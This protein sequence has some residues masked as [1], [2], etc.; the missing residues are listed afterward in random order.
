LI[1]VVGAIGVSW[2]LDPG[3]GVTLVVARLRTR[4]R[5]DFAVAG[6]TDEIGPEHFYPS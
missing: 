1:V 3:E 5:P 6:L 2:A 4:M